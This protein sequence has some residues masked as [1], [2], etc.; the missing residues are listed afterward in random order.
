MVFTIETSSKNLSSDESSYLAQQLQ[1]LPDDASEALVDQNFISSS[2]FS[3]L[4]FSERERLPSFDTGSGHKKADYALR[5]N[6]ENDDFIHT[7]KNPFILVELKARNINLIPGT[8]SYKNTVKQLKKY[9]LAPKSKSAQWGIITNSKHIQLF[10]KHGK[11]IFPATTCLEIT[12]DNIA[13]IVN[14][15]K[16]KIEQPSKALTVAIYNKKGGIGKTTTT[17]NLAATL[18]RYKQQVLVVDFDA[19]QKDLTESLNAQVGS[20]QLGTCLKNQR[21]S[22]CLKQTIYTHTT[23]FRGGLTLSFDIVPVDDEFSATSEDEIRQQI[24]THTLGKKLAALKNL[25]DY[26]LIDASPNWKFH[27]ISAINAADVVLIPTKHNDLRSLKNAAITITKHLPEIQKDR[28]AKTQGLELGAVALPIFFNGEK[29]TTA[30][31]NMAK[32]AISQMISD[33]KKQ[34]GFNLLP[35][36]FPRYQPSNHN[37]EIFELP[38]SAYIANSGFDHIPAVYRYQ[39]VRVYYSLLAKEYFLQ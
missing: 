36:F 7:Q 10:R 26:I 15:L 19:N 33:A 18:A 14:S 17:I 3:A 9:L 6:I 16:Q 31:K 32:K 4:G 39:A 35:Y 25:Y 13:A 12:P 30:A 5:K 8:S 27:S 28:Q 23:K 11:T 24:N 21:D 2:F 37:D 22:D 38:H 29:I 1:N 34:S 20:L